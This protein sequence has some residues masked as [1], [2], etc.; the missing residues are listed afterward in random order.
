MVKERERHGETS[1]DEG[2][3]VHDA[4]DEIDRDKKYNRK[5]K[6]RYGCWWSH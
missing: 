3:R 5:E 4:R 2:A 1:R 6:T